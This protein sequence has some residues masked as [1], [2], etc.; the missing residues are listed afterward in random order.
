[1]ADNRNPRFNMG[2]FLSGDRDDKRFANSGDG[3][4]E[5]NRNSNVINALN[6]GSNTEGTIRFASAS[7][8][9][10][11][12]GQP[13][14]EPS[15]NSCNARTIGKVTGCYKCLNL[16]QGNFQWQK[17]PDPP[18]QRC[19]GGPANGGRF[20]PYNPFCGQCAAC[21]VAR[22]GTEIAVPFQGMSQPC[23][24][25]KTRG[26][27]WNCKDEV[28]QCDDKARYICDPNTNDCIIN[29]CGQDCSGKNCEQC[30]NT[31]T[32]PRKRPN[33]ECLKCPYQDANGN[34]QSNFRANCNNGK[35]ECVD[36]GCVM[37]RPHWDPESCRCV[38]DADRIACD[39]STD[40]VDT[41]V[42]FCIAN[43]CDGQNGRPGPCT[44]CDKCEL[45]QRPDGIPV[46]FCVDQ[47]PKTDQYCVT[48]P[49]T[50]LEEC[51]NCRQACDYT[52]C[53]ECAQNRNG[54]Y[55]CQ[56]RPTGNCNNGYG[57]VKILPCYAP[58]TTNF[59]NLR[60]PCNANIPDCLYCWALQCNGSGAWVETPGWQQF[61]DNFNNNNCCGVNSASIQENAEAQTT[62]NGCQY[63][64][65]DPE[66]LQCTCLGCED[67]NDVEHAYTDNFGK[68]QRICCTPPESL[69]VHNGVGSCFDP[70]TCDYSAGYVPDMDTC[71]CVYDVSVLSSVL[72]P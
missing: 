17:L 23:A 52:K 31:E 69:C 24:K 28:E 42:C 29:K 45:V 71:S 34:W 21:G 25:C 27:G 65:L 53:M 1:M 54:S 11:S 32:D 22:D 43:A 41:N 51:S 36:P 57:V 16:G 13:V 50:N 67:C 19:K 46:P 72:L 2:G 68:I 59:P 4:V 30:I 49:A 48:D 3:P 70:M 26:D 58:N 6:A 7:G 10:S 40:Y 20:Q 33:Y 8:V 38:C 66:T 9:G 15:P 62:C 37:P 39:N 14:R 56:Q 63:E 55:S 18:C 35:C 64:G 61:Y 47:C 12:R 44:A 5:T 60:S